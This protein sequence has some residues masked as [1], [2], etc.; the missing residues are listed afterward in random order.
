[1]LFRFCAVTL[2]ALAS[3]HK[4]EL[5]ARSGF[6]S[7][8]ALFIAKLLFLSTVNVG[9]IREWVCGEEV[10]SGSCGRDGYGRDWP[11]EVPSIGS[12]SPR[13]A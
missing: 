5:S 9:A 8:P 7:A 3:K 1:M 13:W 4:E 10:R 12:E 11:A 2:E 6:S